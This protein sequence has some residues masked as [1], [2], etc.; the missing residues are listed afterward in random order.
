MKSYF[1]IKKSTDIDF[2][3]KDDMFKERQRLLCEDVMS[4]ENEARD[5][6]IALISG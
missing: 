6:V 3:S 1:L 5:N 2:N 4:D